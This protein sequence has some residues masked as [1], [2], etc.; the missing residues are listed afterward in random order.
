MFVEYNAYFR[1]VCLMHRTCLRHEILWRG[2]VCTM[3]CVSDLEN[4][5]LDLLRIRELTQQLLSFVS[6]IERDFN[7]V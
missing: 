2:K 3:I 5:Q 6:C 1:H 7:K 4:I